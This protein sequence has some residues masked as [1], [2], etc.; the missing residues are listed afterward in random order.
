MIKSLFQVLIRGNW[1]TF[2]ILLL[3]PYLNFA[4]IALFLRDLVEADNGRG[5]GRVVG[6]VGQVLRDSIRIALTIDSNHS[7]AASIQLRP[8]PPQI[9]RGS[10][11]QRENL[12]G[13][14]LRLMVQCMLK[15]V[16]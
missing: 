1:V 13:V 12:H 8:P 16:S 3:V 5:A 14:L 2:A 9:G 7:E 15:V 11:P 6:C 4:R 10:L